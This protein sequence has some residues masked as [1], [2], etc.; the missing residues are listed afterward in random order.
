MGGIEKCTITEAIKFT[1][2]NE[3]ENRRVKIKIKIVK[4]K[5]CQGMESA[6]RKTNTCHM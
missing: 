2:V 4:L 1:A 3:I 6:R 5:R